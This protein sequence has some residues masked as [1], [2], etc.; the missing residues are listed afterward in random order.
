MTAA[1]F[2]ALLAAGGLLTFSLGVSL[3]LIRLLSMVERDAIAS[4]VTH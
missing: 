1:K 2:A 4:G 3:G